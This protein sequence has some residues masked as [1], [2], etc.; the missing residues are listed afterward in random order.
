MGSSG[1]IC[2]G[3]SCVQFRGCMDKLQEALAVPKAR[4]EERKVEALRKECL[5]DAGLG[6][7]QFCPAGFDHVIR[8]GYP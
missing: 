5:H 4:D 7:L 1:I 3:C 8:G 6:F 2:G